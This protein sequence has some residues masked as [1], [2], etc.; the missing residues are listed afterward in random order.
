[1][2]IPLHNLLTPLPAPQ[3]PSTPPATAAASQPKAA[4]LDSLFCPITQEPMRDP[5]LAADGF[6]YERAAIATW[7]ARERAA[8]AVAGRLPQPRSPMTNQ[9]LEHEALVPN[10]ALR[11]V[12]EEL[13]GL[14]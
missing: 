9:P 11:A 8:A 1:M 4:Q 12:A 2:P 10:R 6:T 14:G 7:I 13:L 3:P 5:V